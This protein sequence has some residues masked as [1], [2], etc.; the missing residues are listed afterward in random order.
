MTL[1]D[2][3]LLLLFA[4]TIAAFWRHMGIG[5]RAVVA[6]KSHTEKSGVTLLD[7][8]VVLSGMAIRRSAH[9]LF[10]IERR[11]S[12]EFSSVGDVRYP[13]IAIYIG[14]RLR[15]IQLAPFKTATEPDGTYDG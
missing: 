6:A 1:S 10:A 15:A 8:S 2:L 3:F 14:D 12:F 11:Y 13:G 4:L 5:Q 9:S 7:Q